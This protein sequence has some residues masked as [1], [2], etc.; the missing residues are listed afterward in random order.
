M[1]VKEERRMLLI[2]EEAPD[3]E[4]VT[5]DG[6]IKFKSNSANGLRTAGSFYSAIPPTSRRSAPLSLSVSQR[7]TRN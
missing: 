5:T 3:F 7:Y 4:A 6:A 2:G 1:E